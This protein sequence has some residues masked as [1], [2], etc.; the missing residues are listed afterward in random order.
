VRVVL[1]GEGKTELGEWVKE[2]PFRE[3]PGEKGVLV[4]LLERVAGGEW[5]TVDGVQRSKIRK[6]R[7]GKHASAEERNVLG[8][9]LNAQRARCDTLVFSRD[10]DGF[11]ARER[12]IEDGIRRVR[13]IFPDLSVVG[14]MAIENVES[15]ILV[16]LGARGEDLS[17]KDTKRELDGRFGVS[18]LQGKVDAIAGASLE[19]LPPGSLHTWLERAREVFGQ[20]RGENGS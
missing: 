6:Y 10:R 5:T 13:D 14:G 11:D 19:H 17:S 16:A 12:D 1:G 15:W 20:P 2:P 7:A 8:L 4:A 9:A 18:S 3:Q